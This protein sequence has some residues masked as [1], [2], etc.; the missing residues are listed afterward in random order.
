MVVEWFP[1]EMNEVSMTPQATRIS[2]SNYTTKT[3]EKYTKTLIHFHRWSSSPPQYI[4]LDLH[5]TVR[6]ISFLEIGHL[7]VYGLKETVSNVDP[8]VYDTAFVIENG[9]MVMETGLS[10]NEHRLRGSV[11]YINGILNT[12]NGNTFLLNGC[13][14][15]IIPNHSHI[16]TIKVLYF[17]RKD[18]YTPI[19]LKVKHSDHL[20][21]SITYPLFQ[22]TQLQTISINLVVAFGLMGVELA[23]DVKDEELLLLI[24]YRA[25]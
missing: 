6:D 14:K 21:Q 7:I 24:E 1:P 11:H 15:I 9:Q 25:P 17:K 8:S 22:A 10:L 12:K 20:T 18:Q 5:G 23:S 13:D 16:L 19:S 2:I 4:F 3:F